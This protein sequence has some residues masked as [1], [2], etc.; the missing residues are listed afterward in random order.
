MGIPSFFR[1]LKEKYPLII[2]KHDTLKT[3]CLHI[4]FN[5]LIH[6]STHPDDGGDLTQEEMFNLL[7]HNINR[8]VETFK[9]T[10]TLHLATDGVAPRAKLNQQRARRFCTA[11]EAAIKNSSNE[12]VVTTNFDINCIT[13]GTVFMEDLKDFVI[14]FINYKQSLDDNYKK[15]EIVY[16]SDA[17]P[18]EGE[19]KILEYIRLTETNIKHS[20][21]S[22]DADLIFL[23]LTLHKYDVH[24][25]RED[26]DYIQTFKREFCTKCNK[27]GHRDNQCCKLR[28]HKMLCVSIKR[29][30]TYLKNEFDAVGRPY[31][32]DFMIND[33]ILVCFTAG[34]DFIPTLPMLDVK[35]QAIEYLSKTLISIFNGTYLTSETGIN[36][37][38]L[39][40]FMKYL[41]KTED[42]LYLNKSKSL[43][44]VRAKMFRHQ[45]FE[46]IDLS[47][48]TGKNEYYGKKLYVF[49][50]EQKDALCYAY[51]KGMAWIYAYYQGK[52]RNWD[53]F[54]PQHYAPFPS[55][56]CK[57]TIHNM[58]FP[59]TEPVCRL[60][61]LLLVLPPDSK[62]L[63]PHPFQKI[64]NDE[65]LY[66]KKIRIDRFDKL[67]E[68]QAVSRIPLIS[69][70]KITGFFSGTERLLTPAERLRNTRGRD[71]LCLNLKY[72]NKKNVET[73]MGSLR[74]KLL[75]DSK[76]GGNNLQKKYGKV[77][78][79]NNS[80]ILTIIDKFSVKSEV[81]GY[82]KRKKLL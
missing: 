68:W 12:E 49:N 15:L 61:Q 6:I 43:E 44:E 60:I 75:L 59:E 80:S 22:P 41:S 64:F 16:S 37:S 26:L 58:K 39:Q 76:T 40:F 5:A 46:K 13:P 17:V 53:Y 77:N 82:N 55:D 54:Y 70:A 3:D 8:L 42:E 34:N 72:L 7:A 29:L 35:F 48:Q 74:Y 81:T 66:P 30:R 31:N 24:I 4:D 38:R 63:V 36:F 50:D 2:I 47:N 23:G 71:V 10:K 25:I 51:L 73:Y 62:S 14:S 9:P 1:W 67:W 52:S 21:Y 28:L 18:G 33:L 56:I 19:H 45:K 32:L 57:I 11:Q 65:K 79:V 27:T 69:V 78:F 20:I